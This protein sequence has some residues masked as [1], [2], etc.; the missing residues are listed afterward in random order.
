MLTE[1]LRQETM[2]IFSSD[3]GFHNALIDESGTVYLLDFEYAGWDDPAKLV[4]DFSN[5]PD[6]LLPEELSFRF[7]SAVID[8]DETPEY[9]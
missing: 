9:L 7:Q 2:C 5:Q 3:F 6:M 1:E 8:Y 4:C